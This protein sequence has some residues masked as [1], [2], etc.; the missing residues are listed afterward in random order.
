[1]KKLSKWYLLTAS[2]L[3]TTQVVH[4]DTASIGSTD[5]IY[6][7]GSQSGIAAAAGGTT[8][9][10]ITLETGASYLTFSS[11]TG[12]IT[13]NH[14]TGD[15]YNDADG[16]G[17]DPTYSYNSGYGSISGIEAYG[18]G[19][20]TGAFV[21]AGGPCGSSAGPLELHHRGRNVLYLHR[22]NPRSDLL[23][24][25]RTYRGWNWHRTDVLRA[26]HG[27]TTLYLGISDACGYS[28][29][30]SCYADNLGSFSATY[31]E[32]LAPASPST[33]PE[34][35]SFLLLGSGLI[36]VVLIVNVRSKSSFPARVSSL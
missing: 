32:T 9:L 7:A 6:A 31:S 29:G 18:A 34:P 10:A 23:H 33:V 4:A 20:L 22:A 30:P 36:G 28:G 14:G 15:N 1:M 24:R 21:G 3:S 25:G 12:T 35:S 2:I 5:V 26:H 19:Y 16:V 8:P 13:L 17:A 27:A 11:V